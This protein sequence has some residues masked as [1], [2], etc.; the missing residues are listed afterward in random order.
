MDVMLLKFVDLRDVPFRLHAC[1]EEC[2]EAIVTEYTAVQKQLQQ[3]LDSEYEQQVKEAHRLM[4]SGAVD[5]SPEA[6]NVPSNLVDHFVAPDYR[7]SV[8]FGQ[9]RRSR[10]RRKR[11]SIM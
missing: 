9:S 8:R 2:K 7:A 5:I 1:S 4:E 6:I 10:R 3:E 11:C